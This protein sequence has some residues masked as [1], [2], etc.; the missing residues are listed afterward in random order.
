MSPVA[1]ATAKY[2]SARSHTG[3][4]K[5]GLRGLI[6]AAA[7]GSLMTSVPS[8]A[9]ELLY[10]KRTEPAAAKRRRDLHVDVA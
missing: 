10:Q 5:G 2:T 9:L 7:A 8:D 4:Q 3:T 1:H 6:V